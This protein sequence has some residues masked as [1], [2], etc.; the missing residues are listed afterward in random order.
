[1]NESGLPAEAERRSYN[2]VLYWPPFWFFLLLILSLCVVGYLAFQYNKAETRE[3]EL[4]LLSTVADL[5]VH[6]IVEW[7]RERMAD[8]ET[9]AQSPMW[10]REIDTWMRSGFVR[11]TTS[12]M[13][14]SGWTWRHAYGYS[15]VY[16]FDGGGQPLLATSPYVL[17]LTAP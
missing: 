10:L 12:L 7:R 6:E 3:K 15:E 13:I 1:M 16:L 11:S 17:R 4:K 5:K 9:L 8:A 2:G 14:P